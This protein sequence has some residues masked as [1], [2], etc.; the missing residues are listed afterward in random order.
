[1]ALVLMGQRVWALRCNS[2]MQRFSL[3]VATFVTAVLG[4]V[5]PLALYLVA[6][7]SLLGIGYLVWYTKQK[8]FKPQSQTYKALEKLKKKRSK[9]EHNK[10]KHINDQIAY[11]STHWGYTKEQER[12]I[13]KFIRE[14]AYSD[15][16][17]KLTASLFPQ[18]I[19]LIDHCN[20]RKQKGCK[21]EVS[22]R[23]RELTI[24]IK[25]ELKRT[26]T[27]KNENYETTL[28]VYDHLLDEVK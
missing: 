3:F 12:I 16:Y 21:R 7:F 19:S 15:M 26:K 6:I 5:Y 25:E 18:M 17:N 11:I 28:E 20:A 10:Y 4:I 2:S 9:I 14:R 27:L 8:A 23:L 22:K 1:L 24:R 13:E